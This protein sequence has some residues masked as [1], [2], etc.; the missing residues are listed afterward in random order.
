MSNGML[1]E[2]GGIIRIPPVCAEPK[3]EGCSL[4]KFAG[5]SKT[6][7]KRVVDSIEYHLIKPGEGKALMPQLVRALAHYY[8]EVLAELHREGGDQRSRELT[9]EVIDLISSSEF[10]DLVVWEITKSPHPPSR[11]YNR[12]IRSAAYRF[13]YV[14]DEENK[15]YHKRRLLRRFSGGFTLYPHPSFDDIAVRFICLPFFTSASSSCPCQTSEC[16]EALCG[17]P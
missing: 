9:Q 7:M 10:L 13:N 3:T 4:V 11:A 14:W 1:I 15:C 17:H 12:I 5:F 8:P 16:E 6:T 2:N